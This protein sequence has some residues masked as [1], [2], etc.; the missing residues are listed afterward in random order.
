MSQGQILNGLLDQYCQLYPFLVP[1]SNSCIMVGTMLV[2]WVL[3]S[4][5]RD[6]AQ[7]ARNKSH[8]HKRRPRNAPLYFMRYTSTKSQHQCCANMA[9]DDFLRR[10]KE[11]QGWATLLAHILLHLSERRTEC[12][13][14]KNSRILRAPLIS[15]DGTIV[16]VALYCLDTPP[17]RLVAQCT[18]TLE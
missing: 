2:S 3:R 6:V 17:H 11:V 15:T 13:G 1:P 8:P 10:A 4:G 9:G 12:D 16:D 7:H 14:K 5:W 18:F